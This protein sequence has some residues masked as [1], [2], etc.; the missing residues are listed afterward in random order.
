MPACC[1]RNFIAW[2]AISYE[3][4]ESGLPPGGWPDPFILEFETG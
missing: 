2:K 4:I 1:C 3:K